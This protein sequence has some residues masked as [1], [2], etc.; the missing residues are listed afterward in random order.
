M[1]IPSCVSIQFFISQAFQ[2]L[3][4]NHNPSASMRRYFLLLIRPSSIQIFAKKK[5]KNEN[6]KEVLGCI[7]CSSWHYPITWGE[8]VY[9]PFFFF[10]FFFFFAVMLVSHELTSCMCL[11]CHKF[12]AGFAPKQSRVR[13]VHRT[14]LR[15]EL[16]LWAYNFSDLQARLAGKNH[17]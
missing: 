5:W 17:R 16:L 9:L 13:V 2:M 15:Q 12:M 8:I 10:F 14:Q 6:S 4:W 1:E 7:F 11:C 3:F